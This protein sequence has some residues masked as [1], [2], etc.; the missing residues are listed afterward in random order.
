MGTHDE[1]LDA[2]AGDVVD[3][4]P[5]SADDARLTSAGV[6]ADVASN[7]RVLSA[8]AALGG[9]TDD[10]PALP[11][12]RMLGAYEL[13]ERI[14]AGGMGE[15][16]RARQLRPLRREVAVKLLRANVDAGFVLSRF[17]AER[18]T[19]AALDDDGIA[20][21]YD[22][23]A[24]EDGRPYF[25][26]ELVRGIPIHEY[27]ELHRLSA[28]ERIRIFAEVCRAVPHAHQRGIIHRDLKSSNVLVA[29]AEGRAVPKVIDFG[30]AK[31]Q[32]E[33]EDAARRT[34]AG[35]VLG[36]P[37]Y[38]SPEQLDA[39]A[40]VDVRADVFSLG[41]LLYELL[42]GALPV[43]SGELRSGGLAQLVAVIRE[44]VPA[45]PSLLHP[46]IPRELDWITMKA[47]EK[48]RTRRYGS[49]ME[50]ADDL[51][52]HLRH[53]PVLAGPPSATYRLR[54]F[55]R[56]H[57][58]LVT[59]AA[60][61]SL[62]LV[63]GLITTTLQAR[64]ALRAEA[65][66]VESAA[67]AREVNRF[68]ADLLAQANP[69]ENPRGRDM[70]VAEAL[71]GAAARVDG[72]F[73]DQPL[74]E[75]EIRRTIGAAYDA[76]GRVDG[77]AAQLQ[78]AV[79]LTA[80]H[81]S[82]TERI[83]ALDALALARERAGRSEDAV[84]AAREAARIAADSLPRGDDAA[85]A[86]RIALARVLLRAGGHAEADSLFREALAAGRDESSGDALTRSR[87][88]HEYAS[89]LADLGRFEE[90]E[91]VYRESAG[92][93]RAALG[94]RH[95]DVIRGTTNLAAFLHQVGKAGEAESLF[96]VASD[97]ARTTL[98]ERHPDY[99]IAR[100]GA[101]AAWISLG[102]LEQAEAALREALAVFRAA[103][104]DGHPNV[105]RTCGYLGDALQ[106]QGKLDEATAAF[107]EALEIQTAAF[108][109]EHAETFTAANNLASALRLHGEYA[110]A[111]RLFRGARASA[112]RIFGEESF[113][114]AV[115]SHNL[116]KTLAEVGRLREAEVEYGRALD[117]AARTL[118]P[119]HPNLAIFSGNFGELLLRQRRFAA[120]ES[121]LAS[122]LGA[123]EAALG[124]EHPR[125]AQV[126]EW[127]AAAR[128]GGAAR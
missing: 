104:D 33:D 73:D 10:E 38:M 86:A 11:L 46:R 40:T 124:T 3:G 75:A 115:V 13:V 60:T 28:P 65:R 125:T 107:R 93:M 68:L 14:G 26:M 49:P 72:A 44:R 84:A 43:R 95:P 100:M 114:A 30:V 8:V 128:A 119:G 83:T 36:T 118:P 71:D 64:R 15:V 1:L 87:R 22:A 121:V 102:R 61:L 29:A 42:A 19:L 69:E 113:Q 53:E 110:E 96:A 58:T 106:Q 7:L 117:L 78:R 85:V 79:E 99:A 25:V 47:L 88:V 48:D 2:L 120:A 98:G 112:A 57:R 52:R 108:G 105:A 90:A 62:A 67:A 6:E 50:L 51:L 56:R 127:L 17:E 34:Q 70:T 111:E 31:A 4:V 27:C 76:L 101:G 122:S 9:P 59:A 5:L 63:G 39:P 80:R 74:V 103:Y 24:D 35:Q 45:P 81:G 97:A 66:A 18:Q 91:T 92:G 82:A 21:V 55:A 23:G 89:L 20:R 32:H 54:K 16:Y 94:D 37:E 126:V 41:V 116:A 109:S 123:L 77:A 12:P